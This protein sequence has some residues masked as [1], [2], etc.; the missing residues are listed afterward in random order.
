[1]LKYNIKEPVWRNGG[2]VGIA[3]HRIKVDTMMD[4]TV[5]YKDKQGN[6][7]FPHTYRMATR[8]MR[9]YPTK[10]IARGIVLHIIPIRDF[11]VVG[12]EAS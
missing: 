2:A 6:F 5:S 3:A 8:K 7:V 4:V 10:K 12:N 11:E 1:V 9:K